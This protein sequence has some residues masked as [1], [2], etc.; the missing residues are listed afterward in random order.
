[1]PIRNKRNDFMSY[2]SE[3]LLSA[4]VHANLKYFRIDGNIR[5]NR[6]FVKLTIFLQLC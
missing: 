3:W 4:I 5:S 1:M 2:A 6:S